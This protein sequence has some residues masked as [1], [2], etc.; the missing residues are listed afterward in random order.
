MFMFARTQHAPIISAITCSHTDADADLA[1]ADL[2]TE[3]D[4]ALASLS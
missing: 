4:G 2:R 3:L 1:S